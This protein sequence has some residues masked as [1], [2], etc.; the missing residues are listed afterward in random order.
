MTSKKHYKQ[1]AEL[2]KVQLVKQEADYTAHKLN[3][4]RQTV[5]AIAEGLADIFEQDN[6][7]FRRGTFLTACGILEDGYRVE[8]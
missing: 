5:R 7:N 1:V 2:V 3:N 6:P 4:R 8:R